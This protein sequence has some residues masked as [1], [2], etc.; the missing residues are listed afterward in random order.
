MHVPEFVADSVSPCHYVRA[1]SAFFS[2]NPAAFVPR[3]RSADMNFG[4][5]SLGWQA[6]SSLVARLLAMRALWV[7]PGGG[8]YLAAWPDGEAVLTEWTAS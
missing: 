4:Q 2:Q 3:D 6:G 8:A 5:L 1:V 7:W